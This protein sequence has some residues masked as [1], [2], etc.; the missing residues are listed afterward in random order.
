[1]HPSS[2]P[3]EVAPEY[4]P[5]RQI[6]VVL[7]GLMAGMFLAALDQSIVATA[8]PSIT[9]DLGG[10][11]RLSWV[12][13]AYL[14][15][16]TASTPLWGKISDLYGR[17][18]IFQAAIGT[19]LLGSVL[20]GFSQD[21][22]QLIAF[23][24]VQ[25]LG[26]GGLFALAL[27]TIGDVVPPRERGRYQ[28]WFAAVFGTSSVLGPV[29][30]GWLA[31]GPGWQ[32]IFWINLPIGGAALIVTSVALRLPHVPRPHRIDY[33]GA[34]LIVA[35]VSAILL[36]TTWAG[37]A[38]GWG[39]PT[40][41]SLLGAGLLLAVVFVRVERRAVEPIIP[42][43]LFGDRV[44]AASSGFVFLIGMA[45]FGSL[46]FTPLYLQVVQG[47]SPT[48]SGLALLPMVAGIFS[49]SITAGR[50]ASRTGRY[51]VFPI[52]GTATVLVGVTLLSRLGT[53][54][55][56]WQ[57]AVALS[58]L[59][60]GLGGTM[61][62]IL[63]AVQNSV[64]RRHMGT[65][66]SAVTFF[67]M[68]GG[69]VGT[70]V[71]GAT[72]GIRLTH[73]LSGLGTRARATSS[74]G[75]DLAALRALPPDVRNDVLTAYADALGDVFLVAV[76]VAGLALVVALLIPEVRLRSRDDELRAS[77]ADEVTAPA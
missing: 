21:I 54:T 27:A 24:A 26:G 77:P 66:T 20:S 63:T 51:R 75:G 64:D 11:D 69:A 40:A 55:P 61:Q 31:E 2:A 39:S 25:G 10:L 72:L 50:L 17:R 73:H 59:G 3:A 71:F 58:I 16:S 9:S 8:L 56:Y 36:A 28:G 62:I 60:A 37:D 43:E 23:R 32:W 41:V 15:T 70:A 76:P 68:M 34:A 47:M 45:M 19:F 1:M 67:R 52:L 33:L 7:G 18:P 12:V 22:S 42:M 29:L 38:Y 74:D 35:A 13:T 46:V 44:F 49:T 30:G 48:E 65:A 4:L 57:V 14:L 53:E 5:H 6:V